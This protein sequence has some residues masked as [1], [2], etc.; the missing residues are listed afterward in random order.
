MTINGGAK[1]I[2]LTGGGAAV[3]GNGG[4]IDFEGNTPSLTNL[5]YALEV[6]N[7]TFTNNQVTGDGGAIY[8]GTASGSTPPGAVI[9]DHCLFGTQTKPGNNGAG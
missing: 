7:A 1:G 9:V 8:V 2:S 5:P 3:T 6:V 4:A